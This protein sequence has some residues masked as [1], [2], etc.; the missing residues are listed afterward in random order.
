VRLGL[1]GLDLVEGLAAPARGEQQ[2]Q[3]LDLAPAAKVH[4][5]AE[6]AAAVGARRGLACG[7][8]AEARDQ[9]GRVGGGPGIGQVDVKLQ[10]FPRSFAFEPPSRC[11]L[12]KAVTRMLNAR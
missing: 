4:D 3:A 11:S 8:V 10:R 9:L 7:M 5:I 12:S 1:L 2:D 6:I